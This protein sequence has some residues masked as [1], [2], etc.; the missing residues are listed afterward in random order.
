MSAETAA[1][2][3]PGLVPTALQASATV[4]EHER[5]ARDTYRLRLH[6]PTIARQILPG[7]FFMVRVPGETDPLLGRP[8]ALFDTY[9][10]DGVPAGF[11]FGYVVVGKM[12]S[13]IRAWQPGQTADVWGPLGNGFPAPGSGHLMMIAGGIGQTPFLAV[14]REAL[15]RRR[16]GDPARILEQRPSKLTLSY[17]VRSA[18]YLAGLEQFTMPGL[19]LRLAT[20]DGSHGHRGF[21]TEL[22]TAAIRGG[23]RPDRVYCCGPEPMM[24]AVAR[25]CAEHG[26]ECWLSLE[27]PMACGFGA[28]F[29]CVTRVRQDDGS[30]DYRR[31]CVEGPVFRADSL[32]LD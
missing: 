24:H 12:T 23:D 7:Q 28:C 11:D 10:Q 8:F 32:Y 6:C 3:L 14:A 26:V 2:P 16:Y 27:S 9:D 17:G 4:V 18:E 22:L 25:I 19:D 21:V 29:S 20:D 31:T 5:L 15:G 1:A 13:L 30:W